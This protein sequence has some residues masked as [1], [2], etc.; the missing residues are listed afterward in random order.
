MPR[1]AL[2]LFLV[3][4]CMSLSGCQVI[5]DMLSTDA[6][7]DA[8]CEGDDTVVVDGVDLCKQF[9]STGKID[10]VPGYHVRLNGQA[11]CP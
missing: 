4:T 5:L 11:V 10:C 6:I 3:V 9:E 2:R 7:I 8:S 1:N